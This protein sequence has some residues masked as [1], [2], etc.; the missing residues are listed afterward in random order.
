MIFGI[1]KRYSVQ[2]LCP[3]QAGAVW[4][5]WARTDSLDSATKLAQRAAHIDSP[6]SAAR[7]WDNVTGKE[8]D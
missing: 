1:R 5:Q 6:L 2:I 4:R 7:I 8:S 3:T